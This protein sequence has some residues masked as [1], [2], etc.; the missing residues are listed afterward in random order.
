MQWRKQGSKAADLLRE[1]L[2]AVRR[3]APDVREAAAVLGAILPAVAD[4]IPVAPAPPTAAPAAG[5]PRARHRGSGTIAVVEDDDDV[6]RRFE[7]RAV[8]KTG[9]LFKDFDQE[10]LTLM[11][12]FHYMIGNPD[13]SINGMHN[14][15]LVQT[16][17]NVTATGLTAA[18]ATVVAGQTF[19]VTLAL[20]LGEANEKLGAGPAP[21]G[22]SEPRGG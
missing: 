2:A 7:G 22:R 1:R 14:V 16:A 20:R 3:E 13:Y 9:L 19:A 10:S 17:A 11:T 12:V 18:P 4:K 8:E 15:R 6:A 5:E 21:S